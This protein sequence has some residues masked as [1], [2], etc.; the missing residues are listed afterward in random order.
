[1]EKTFRKNIYLLGIDH[2]WLKEISVDKNN[3]VLINQKHFYDENS[4]EPKAMHKGGKNQR[5]L[6]EVLQKFVYSFKGYFE[7]KNF[8]NKQNVNIYN[9]TPGSYVDAFERK[10]LNELN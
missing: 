10:N 1:L 9:C 5:A 2:S 4:S 3:N 6:H 7:I 8:A